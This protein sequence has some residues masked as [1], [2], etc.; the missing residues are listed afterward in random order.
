MEEQPDKT[1]PGLHFTWLSAHFGLIVL[2]FYRCTVATSRDDE[3]G[4]DE[5]SSKVW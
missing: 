5:D 4:D 3:D 2:Q 1:S